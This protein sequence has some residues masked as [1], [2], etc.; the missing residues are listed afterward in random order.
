V[1][2]VP[3]DILGQTQCASERWRHDLPDDDVPTDLGR[4]CTVAPVGPQILQAVPSVRPLRSPV[5]RD[6]HRVCG[7]PATP[8]ER[9]RHACPCLPPRCPPLACDDAA[10]GHGYATAAARALLQW[11]LDTLDLNR[12]QAKTDTRNAASARVLEKPRETAPGLWLL[13]SAELQLVT[14]LRARH[15][16]TRTSSCPGE[17]HGFLRPENDIK[18]ISWTEDFLREDPSVSGEVAKP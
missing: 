9:Q 10:W 6:R 18:L 8:H 2:R 15:F 5:V 13:R 17:G 12:V 16:H 3:K 4:I 1:T 11:A 7:C 14:A